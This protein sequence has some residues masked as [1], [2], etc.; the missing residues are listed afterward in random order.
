MA[1]ANLAKVKKFAPPIMKNRANTIVGID[2]LR[3]SKNKS[4]IAR[5]AELEVLADEEKKRKANEEKLK[6]ELERKKNRDPKALNSEDI[7]LNPGPTYKKGGS[8]K[9]SASKRADGIAQRGK[10]RGR[11]Y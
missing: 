6:D 3:D 5:T 1:N 7:M 10:T 11:N 8:V 2:N 9:S 4:P